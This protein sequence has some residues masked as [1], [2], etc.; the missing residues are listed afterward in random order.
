MLSDPSARSL[1]GF[2]APSV[3][4]KESGGFTGETQ[5]PELAELRSKLLRSTM[6]IRRQTLGAFICLV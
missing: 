2:L 4:N 6:S 5:D 3:S 1:V